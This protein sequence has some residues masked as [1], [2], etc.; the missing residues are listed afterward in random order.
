MV[1]VV[2][3]VK[4]AHEPVEPAGQFDQATTRPHA[5]TMHACT[6]TTQNGHRYEYLVRR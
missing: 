6:N 1:D 2:Q 5:A 4:D 3:M